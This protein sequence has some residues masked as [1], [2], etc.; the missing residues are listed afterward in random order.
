M[1]PSG[2]RS[3]TSFVLDICS[4]V[5]SGSLRSMLPSMR[6]M[7]VPSVYSSMDLQR[8]RDTWNVPTSRFSTSTSSPVIFSNIFDSLI[9][10]D[11]SAMLSRTFC[12]RTTRE[13]TASTFINVSSG[14]LAASATA[15]GGDFVSL[16]AALAG[17]AGDWLRLDEAAPAPDAEL[18]SLPAG[19]DDSTLCLLSPFPAA[20]RD[21]TSPNALMGDALAPLPM[22]AKN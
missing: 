19:C 1:S 6:R 17:P 2:V 8:S 16:A 13:R 21:A 10:F 4:T 9:C 3:V 20:S 22:V 5:P 12:R 18:A 11:C 15:L 14:L 7:V